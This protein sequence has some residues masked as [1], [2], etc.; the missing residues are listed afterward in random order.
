MIDTKFTTVYG[1]VSSLEKIAQ[2]GVVSF[3]EY[4]GAIEDK[5]GDLTSDEGLQKVFKLIDKDDNGFIE[6]GDFQRVA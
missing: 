2:D 1:M 5:L 4:M 6:I 3:E